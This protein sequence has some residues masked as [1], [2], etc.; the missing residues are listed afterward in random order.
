MQVHPDVSAL[1]R[2]EA[3]RRI[4]LLNEAYEFIK[5]YHGWG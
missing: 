1:P 4:K 3:E 2:T 5:S